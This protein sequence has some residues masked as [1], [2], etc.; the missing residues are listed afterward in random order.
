MSRCTPITRHIDELLDERA[1]NSAVN[2]TNRA[3]I[4]TM[5]A[6]YFL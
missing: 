4:T 6:A 1:A 5:A 3:T 2:G